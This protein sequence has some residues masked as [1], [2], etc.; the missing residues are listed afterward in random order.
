M[1]RSKTPC[2][3]CRVAANAHPIHDGTRNVLVF[4]HVLLHIAVAFCCAVLD[5]V[6]TMQRSLEK[7]VGCHKSSVFRLS[8]EAQFIGD[9]S[10]K[11]FSVFY[12]CC[13]LCAS[14]HTYATGTAVYNHSEAAMHSS[15]YTVQVQLLHKNC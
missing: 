3:A 6:F 8:F 4:N 15:N 10:K 7:T 13:V 1:L 11:R 2:A 14:L 5:D 9:R 12:P